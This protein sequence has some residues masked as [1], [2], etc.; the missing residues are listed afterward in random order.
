MKHNSI[1]F[2]R[3]SSNASA[4][5]SLNQV[6]NILMTLKHNNNNWLEALKCIPERC[7]SR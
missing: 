3:L 5:L 2:S 1:D 4:V 6:Y 7:L